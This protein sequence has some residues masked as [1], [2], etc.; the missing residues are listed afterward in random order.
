[1][2]VLLLR[3]EGPLQAWGD[4]PALSWRPTGRWPTKSGVVGLLANALGRGRE[5]SVED[6]ASLAY[7]VRVDRPG[8][9]LLD[10]HTVEEVIPAQLA[11]AGRPARRGELRSAIT[12]RAYLADAAFLA[13]LEGERAFLERLQGALKNPAR[14]LYL[15]RRSCL[16][17]PPPYLADGL[18]EGLSLEEALRAYPPLGEEAPR[19]MVLEAGSGEG[20]PVLDQPAGSFARRAHLPRWVREVAL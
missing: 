13:G 18:V 7:G 19:L 2:A 20:Y 16:P 6:I 5:E 3:L 1:M 8:S 15:G 11:G 12:R 17:S 10:F 9:L 14:P 4:A